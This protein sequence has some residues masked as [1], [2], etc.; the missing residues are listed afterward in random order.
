MPADPF[1]PRLRPGLYAGDYGHG[2]YG[3]LL[4]LE[5]WRNSSGPLGYKAVSSLANCTCSFEVLSLMSRPI[6]SRSPTL[7]LCVLDT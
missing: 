5:E 4:D 7:G 3:T 2:F 1:V 6:S